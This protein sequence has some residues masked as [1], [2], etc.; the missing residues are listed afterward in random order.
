MPNFIG[1]KVE[2]WSEELGSITGTV[3]SYDSS[4]IDLMDA[5]VNGESNCVSSYSVD[6]KFI[7]RLRILSISGDPPPSS[8][9]SSRTTS[10]RDQR[11]DRLRNIPNTYSV[12]V[13]PS[14]PPRVVR[15]QHSPPSETL[16]VPKPGA[17]KT[18]DRSLAPPAVDSSGLGKSSAA[19]IN[20][21]TSASGGLRSR[22]RSVGEGVLGE[23]V[24][25]CESEPVSNSILNH[26]RRNNSKK[27][28]NHTGGRSR[29]WGNSQDHQHNQMVDGW[30]SVRVEDFIDEDFDFEA[31]LALFDKQAFYEEADAQLAADG[32]QPPPR[33]SFPADDQ[34]LVEGPNGI[35]FV[36]RSSHSASFTHGQSSIGSPFPDSKPSFPAPLT[37]KPVVSRRPLEEPSVPATTAASPPVQKLVS[38]AKLHQPSGT[39]FSPTGQRVPVLSPQSHQR[40]LSYLATGEIPELKIRTIGL[41]WARLLEGAGQTVASV[42]TH[43]LRQTGTHGLRGQHSRHPLRVVVLTGCPNVGSTLAVNT[44]RQLANR[45]ACVLVHPAGDPALPSTPMAADSSGLDFVCSGS[46][47][48]PHLA[49]AYRA[50]LALAKTFAPRPAL[51]GLL[52]DDYADDNGWDDTASEEDSQTESEDDDDEE[53]RQNGRKASITASKMKC[54]SPGRE[55]SQVGR[56]WISRI[57]GL[58]FVSKPSGITRRPRNT[59]VDLLIL[60]QPVSQLDRRLQQWLSEHTAIGLAIQLYPLAEHVKADIQAL[61]PHALQTWFFQLGLPTFP[62]EAFVDG[63]FSSLHLVDVGM[64]RSLVSKVTGDLRVLPPPTMFET[65]SHLRLSTEP[66]K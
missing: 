35:G 6:R 27:S 34:V 11:R 23:C 46:I 2:L 16:C 37:S 48:C 15:L 44:A 42:V 61:A 38:S 63:V 45:G 57:P 49:A 29:R 21:T 9:E 58:K 39:W 43:H 60:G 8:T 1:F 30:D 64:T 13:C 62:P 50:E 20:R 25:G 14:S 36:P 53:R 40:L 10:S 65:S 33:P 17:S 32:K 55:L 28:R 52:Q 7:Q 4:R 26:G 54:S 12:Y 22:S 59:L 24:S 41:S 18:V 51:Y 66:G 3:K 47:S 31:N 19:S 5:V 56:M